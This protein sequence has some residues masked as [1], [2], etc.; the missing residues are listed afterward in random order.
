[1]SR[2]TASVFMPVND[3]AMALQRHLLQCAKARSR[4][5][6]LSAWAERLHGM[7]LPRLVTTAALASVTL[8][9][10]VHWL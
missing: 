6:G 7:I 5:F 3:Q 1:M 8:A 10:L 4:W 9:V 2:T